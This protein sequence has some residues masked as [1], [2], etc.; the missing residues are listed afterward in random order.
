MPLGRAGYIGQR[1]QAQPAVDTE[2]VYTVPLNYII[3][4]MIYTITLVTDANAANRTVTFSI[5]DGTNTLYATTPGPN[6]TA[7][8]TKH[9]YLIPGGITDTT[10]D[11]AGNFRFYVPDPWLFAAYTIA[12]TTANMQVGDRYSIARMLSEGWAL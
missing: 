3:H 10:F 12:T 1:T 7:G 8:T 5:T 9:Y 2:S 4:V 11:S 6:Q